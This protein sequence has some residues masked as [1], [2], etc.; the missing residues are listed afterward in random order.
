LVLACDEVQSIVPVT[1]DGRPLKRNP[2]GTLLRRSLLIA[3]RSLLSLAYIVH[4][5]VNCFL[6]L[7]QDALR[8]RVFALE[9]AGRSMAARLA[10]MAITTSNSMSVN[11]VRRGFTV[12]PFILLLCV[13]DLGPPGSFRT[14][15]TLLSSA[16]FKV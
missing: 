14:G 4:A 3:S 1:H 9:R 7:M 10:M 11:P 15:R 6:S 5:S 13:C 2:G 12:I 16:N 8:A